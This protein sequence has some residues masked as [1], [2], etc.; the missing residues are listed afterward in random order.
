MGCRALLLAIA[1]LLAIPSL[2]RGECIAIDEGERV[3]AV[4]FANG[5]RS[6]R[7][8]ANLQAAALESAY[9]NLGSRYG[10]NYVFG[11]T[12]N[13]TRGIV[14]DVAE[15][16]RQ[17]AS[18]AGLRVD[19]VN[20]QNL[21][22]IFEE[23]H[24]A[25]APSPT[26]LLRLVRLQ[27]AWLPITLA[28]VGEIIGGVGEALLSFEIPEREVLASH[29]ACYEENLQ[30]GARVII[31]AHS[32]GN[33][34][35]NEAVAQVSVAQEERARSIAAIGVATPASRRANTQS[36]YVTAR[37]DIVIN[38]WRE[39]LRRGGMGVLGGNV[40]NAGGANVR[41]SWNH[42]FQTSYFHSDLR[43][44]EVIDQYMNVLARDLP[45]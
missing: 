29:V 6:D 1:I 5:I 28:D 17:K 8:Y 37:D 33:L 9:R 34:F 42:S 14:A 35:A 22:A 41:D 20:F 30:G 40:N 18:E 7:S 3:T 15:V 25:V 36:F 31:V 19:A 39:V 11:A 2:A 26:G 21:A 45:Y 12:V 38:G 44:R 23:W 10:G 16:L 43:S 24:R 4:Y 32:Q 27:F 13:P